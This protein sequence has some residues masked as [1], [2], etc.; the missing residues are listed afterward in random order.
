M[1]NLPT[2]VVVVIAVMVAIEALQAFVF[3]PAMLR[4]VLF[5]FAFIPA[6]YS[7]QGTAVDGAWLWSPI[8]Y[9]LLHG[10]WMHLLLNTF[11]LAAFGAVVARRIGALRFSLF[12]VLSALASAGLFGLMHWGEVTVM[13]GASGV[14]SGLMG[15]AA[16]FAFQ[17]RGGLI[18]A[19]SEGLPL[20]SVRDALSNRSVITF[21]AVWF[22]INFLTAFGVAPGSDGATAIAWEA[23]VGGFLFGFLAFALF[24]PVAKPR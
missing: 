8:S 7:A 21:L 5:Q 13:V 20:L 3:S 10:G 6:R 11:W 14:V 19:G 1:F 24:D 22:G 23:H 9:S 18:P 15:A 16:R 12:W 2:A 4:E 17:G